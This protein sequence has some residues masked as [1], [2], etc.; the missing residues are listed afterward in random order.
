MDGLDGRQGRLGRHHEGP[1]SVDWPAAAF[2]R[3][4]ADMYPNAPVLLSTRSSTDQWFK[5]FSSQILE[6]V[7]RDVPNGDS[8][9]ARLHDLRHTWATLALQA[10]VDV[11]IV[12]E[13]LGHASAKITW[14]IYQHVT[15][16]M[17]TDAAETV[18]QLIFGARG[19]AASGVRDQ[20]V[21][22]RPRPSAVIHLRMARPARSRLVAGG[23]GGT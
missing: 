18:A 11:K 12:S 14:D 17:Q 2:W 15:P 4:L 3:E 23:R 5:G 16:A 6:V 21:S 22:T 19:R 7:L 8:T 9:S 13:R 1:A 20:T 10:S